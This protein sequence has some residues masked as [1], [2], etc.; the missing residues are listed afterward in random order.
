MFSFI[1]V[2]NYRLFKVLLLILLLRAGVQKNRNYL[3][4]VEIILKKKI[5]VY[6]FLGSNT[7]RDSEKEITVLSQI[8]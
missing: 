2:G 3:F 1:N 8:I 4:S 6:L 5:Q 7:V